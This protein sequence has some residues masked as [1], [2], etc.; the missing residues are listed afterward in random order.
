MSELEILQMATPAAQALLSCMVS[1]AWQATK[2]RFARLLGRDSEG[3]IQIIEGD[4]EES[5]RE[6]LE[7]A[8]DTSQVTAE[9]W[10]ARFRQA[11][12]ANPEMADDLRTLLSELGNDSDAGSERVKQNAVAKD[13]AVVFQQSSGVQNYY[14][15]GKSNE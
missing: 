4:L 5:R 1:D 14:G 3:E 12:L 10:K 7:G 6:I 11:L 15:S 2:G 9:V 8:S 13:N